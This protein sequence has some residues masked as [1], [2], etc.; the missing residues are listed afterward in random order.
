MLISFLVIRAC[1][2]CTLAYPSTH[3]VNRVRS[4]LVYT[5]GI[6]HRFRVLPVNIDQTRQAGRGQ[7]LVVDD[8]PMNRDMLSRRLQRKGFEVA[9]SEDGPA[10]LAW[11]DEH[12]C[13]V[14]LLDIMM[15]GMSGIEVLE[16]LRET[17]A[18]A[19]LPI[20]MA[21]AKDGRDDIVDALRRGANDYVTKPIDFPVVL[22]RV[23]TQLA[24]KRAHEEV[25]RHSR[26]MRRVFGRYLTDDIAETLLDHPEGLDLSGERREITI[27]MADIRGF[28]SLAA[29]REPTEVVQLVNHFLSPMTDVIMRHGGT[30]DEFIGDAILA[31]FGAPKPCDDHAERAVRCA[32]DMQREMARVNE[33]N[34]SV[35]LPDVQTGIGI[36][37]GEVVVGN[38]GSE[39]RA[40]YG[41]V[42]HAVN[43]TARIESFSEGGQILVS[44]RTLAQCNGVARVVN[45]HRVRPKG[46]DADVT[47]SEITAAE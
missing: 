19:A 10:A 17:R 31:L 2:N 6:P 37:T 15:P 21:T 43:F 3:A 33:Q 26:F 36:N 20:I 4:R 32:I 46:F 7:L 27:L 11:L 30:I 45:E 24:L 23:E 35:N 12:P 29:Q 22:A 9:V 42:G 34:R 25:E 5:R 39:Q 40:K 38:I 14:V 8:N 16:R 41:V 18:P 47:L 1:Q 44:E 13:D 28:T